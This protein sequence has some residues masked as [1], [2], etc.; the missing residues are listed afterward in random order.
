MHCLGAPPLR[1]T[2][3][4]SAYS[5]RLRCVSLLCS[6]L[7]VSLSQKLSERCQGKWKSRVLQDL[8]RKLATSFRKFN[9]IHFMRLFHTRTPGPSSASIFQLVSGPAILI[10]ICVRYDHWCF[11]TITILICDCLP[12][13][14]ANHE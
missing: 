12:R 11:C 2:F 5:C 14:S 10:C 3:S 1:T 7:Q 9:R 4:Y 6:G 13:N 8:S